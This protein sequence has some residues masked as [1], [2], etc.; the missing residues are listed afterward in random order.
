M[1]SCV[2]NVDFSPN[3]WKK[4]DLRWFKTVFCFSESYGIRLSGLE[5]FCS[6]WLSQDRTLR[7]RENSPLLSKARE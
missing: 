2:F 6:E 5:L 3:S 7:T 4:L 1:H